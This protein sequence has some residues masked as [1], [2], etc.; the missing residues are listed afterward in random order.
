MVFY[1]CSVL[2]SFLIFT[3]AATIDG[4]VCGRKPPKDT[5][6]GPPKFLPQYVLGGRDVK[7]KTVYPFVVS[8]SRLAGNAGSHTAISA[9]R[10]HLSENIEIKPC[11]A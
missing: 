11:V 6:D 9:R 2:V 7:R 10:F 1:G 3:F 8:A 4:A 5:D